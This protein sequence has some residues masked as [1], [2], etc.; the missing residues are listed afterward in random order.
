MS[1]KEEKMKYYSLKKILANNCL[2]NV[3]FGERSNGKT[4]ACLDLVLK[5]FCGSGYKN[6]AA[7]IRRM[8][9]DFKQ[10][11]GQNYF[12]N[13]VAAGLVSKYTYGQWE[14]I[15]Y[16]S[17]AWFLCRYDENGKRECM[18][19]P[20]AYAFYLS[21]S[22][23][24]KGNSYP[25]VKTIIFDEFISRYGYLP[26]EFVL[27]TNTLSTIIRQRGDV[28]VFMLGNTVNKYCPY[29][30]EMG[31]SHVKEMK[32][33]DIDIYTYG[34]TGELT[35]AVEYTAPNIKGKTSDKYFAFDNPKLKMITRGE[36]EINIY[37]HLPAKYKPKDIL[38]TFFVIFGDDILHAD[39]V[40]INNDI[41]VYMH[42]KTTPIKDETTD[43]VFTEE[44]SAKPNYHRN[45]LLPTDKAGQKIYDLIKADKVFFQTNDI[46]EIFR[47]YI[48]SCGKGW[49]N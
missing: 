33:G 15:F 28:R 40:S 29:F 43:Y 47:N 11:R 42:K 17:G 14:D 3:I 27:F 49:K 2:Y 34:E 48:L 45:I 4:F 9:T 46:G 22:E 1:K 38:F 19:T 39:I 23:H 31:L 8:D 24:D 37:P 36:W 7:I 18:E 6:Q 20:L 30:G 35:V 25:Y 13:V 10:G 32:H 41:F 26:D 21:G 5:D 16:K 12:K 44:Y